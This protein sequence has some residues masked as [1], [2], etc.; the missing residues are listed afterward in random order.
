MQFRLPGR[1]TGVLSSGVVPYPNDPMIPKGKFF[2][3]KGLDQNEGVP[4]MMTSKA[5]TYKIDT[6]PFMMIASPWN[7][8]EHP[9]DHNGLRI[10]DYRVSCIA[11]KK[12]YSKKAYHRWRAIRL[13]RTAASLVLPDKG[14]K[15]CDYLLF[16]HPEMRKMDRDELFLAVDKAIV[17]ME[18]VVKRDW[19]AH[20]RKKRPL[21]FAGWSRASYL[22]TLDD[23]LSHQL[24]QGKQVASTRPKKVKILR[25]KLDEEKR[26]DCVA[27]IIQDFG[28]FN[29]AVSTVGPRLRLYSTKWRANSGSSSSS[30]T[31]GGSATTVNGAGATDS[32]PV[33]LDP[34]IPGQTLSFFQKIKAFISFYKGGLKELWSNNKAAAGIQERLRNGEYV[35]RE[36]FQIQRRNPGD[37]RR[38]IPFGFLVVMIPE[39]I[40]LTIWLFPGFCPSTCI[41]F[42]QI[43]GM[44]KKHDA[45]KQRLYGQALARIESLGLDASSFGA[46]EKL[47]NAVQ[48]G[49]ADIFT[50]ES[51]NANDLQLICQFMN[52]GKKGL[53]TSTESLRAKL[54]SHMEYIKYDDRLLANEQL[55]GQLG[56]TELHRACQERGI[57]TA[58]YPESL[59]R[60]SLESWT[61]L[62]QSK[63]ASLGMLPIVWSRL[64]LFNKQVKL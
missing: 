37:K 27:D 32:K 13:L 33:R 52:I 12:H 39:L 20:G 57:P 49:A 18:A 29:N 23:E 26:I 7:V 61:K 2:K 43:K 19:E 64:V 5:N 41:T 63:G 59:L 11:T 28:S 46:Y 6:R 15:R 40:P 60:S 44:A 8:D 14:L 53:F 31:I 58:D 25:V 34:T 3:P 24:S 51:L 9:R 55:V 50:L 1:T 56:L 10:R 45:T 35:S 16:A 36:E 17:D 54:A 62:T 21:M 42:G 38:L 48:T 47:H 4:F 22:S 30:S